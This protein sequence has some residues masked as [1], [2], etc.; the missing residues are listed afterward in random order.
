MKLYA[1]VVALTVFMS[2]FTVHAQDSVTVVEKPV[3][4]VYKNSSEH[5]RMDKKWTAQWQLFGAGPNGTSESA[6]IG[7][8]HLD[9]NSVV[10]LEVG[11]GG[12]SGNSIFIDDKYE[13]SGSTV[14]LHYKKFFGNSFY[15]KIGL[16]YRSVTYKYKYPFT[17]NQEGF[18]G[19]S[20][21]AGLV[22]GNQWQWENFTLGCD[23]I[24]LS[25]PFAST[26]KSET[27][28]SSDSF[29]RDE[30]NSAQQRYLRNGF[31]QALRFYVGYT[32]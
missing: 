21:G 32:F 3:E 8:Y 9:R 2:W 13:L 25:L 19:E 18:T 12:I 6:I 29:Y 10:Q 24:G 14:G 23:W 30:L 22:I 26:V 20:L 28:T 27:L 1:V 4:M 5:N 17:G 16:D 11:S 15:A 7:G 31:A